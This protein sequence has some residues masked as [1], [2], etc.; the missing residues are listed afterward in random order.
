MVIRKTLSSL[1]AAGLV[2]GSTAAVAAEARDASPVSKS[3]D[4]AGIGTF[5]IL[6]GL[7]IVAGV[8]AIV[9]A[10]GGRMTVFVDSGVRRGSDVV[11]AVALGADA[12]LA[13]RAPLYGLAAFGEPGVAR[14]IE[15]L[16]SET[17]RTMAMLGARTVGEVSA[18]DPA[19]PV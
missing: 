18:A 15:L 4:L 2:L 11:K 14:A 17:V 9:G 12:V 16:R 3:E 10:V 1:V 5:G 19:I 6:L 7:L 8:V 13:G